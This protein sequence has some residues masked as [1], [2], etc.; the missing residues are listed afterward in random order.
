MEHGLREPDFEEI[1]G[2][3]LVRFYAPEYILSLIPE[4]GKIDLEKLGLNKR[5]I[6]ALELMVNEQEKFTI[7]KGAYYVAREHV[8]TR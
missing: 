3:F 5:Q 8:P 1:A 6:K 7:K 2:C 4:Q